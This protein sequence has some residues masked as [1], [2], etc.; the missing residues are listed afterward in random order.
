MNPADNVDNLPAS[1]LAELQ[2]PAG[3]G[4]DALLVRSVGRRRLKRLVEFRV[5]RNPPRDKPP[6]LAADHR[7]ASIPA[8]P[9]ATAVITSTSSPSA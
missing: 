5:D 6:G 2:A 3:A 4:K 9:R 8:A 7:R 1:Y